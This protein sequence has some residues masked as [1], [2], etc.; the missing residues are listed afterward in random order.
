MVLVQ[1]CRLH[2]NL[3]ASELDQL[4]IHAGQDHVLYRLA[5]AEGITQSE[6]AEALCVDA[7]T[8]AKTLGRLERDRL[9]ERRSNPDDAREWR[10]HLTN[11]GRALVRPV[12]DIWTGAESRLT[13]GLSNAERAS[14][15]RLLG[16]VLANLT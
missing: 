10:V 5:I 11:D 16:H 6:L 2:R 3:V 14:L 13:M 9:I 8:V 7:T 12:I 1:I 15:R 4:K